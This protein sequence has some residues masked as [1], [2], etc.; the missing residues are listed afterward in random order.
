[1]MLGSFLGKPYRG[2]FAPT[3]EAR[4]DPQTRSAH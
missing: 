1:L 3:D 4:G 2:R